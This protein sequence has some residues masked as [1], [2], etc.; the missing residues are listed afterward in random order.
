ME[1]NVLR[2]EEF[3]IIYH[4]T[5]NG[6]MRRGYHCPECGRFYVEG[7]FTIES[8]TYV[9]GRSIH[10]VC[11]GEKLLATPYVF[12]NGAE[13]RKFLRA[14]KC[15]AA[16]TRA[17]LVNKKNLVPALFNPSAIA[18]YKRKHYH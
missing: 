5:K 2:A 4:G 16:M 7:N 12:E 10:A 1:D 17:I 3:E 11:C 13:V 8:S 14:I 15:S 18:E 9:W 6:K